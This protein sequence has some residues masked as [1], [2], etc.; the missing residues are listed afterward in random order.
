MPRIRGEICKFKGRLNLP[1]QK[2][3]GVTSCTPH[4]ALE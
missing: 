4:I 2:V 3:Y 1:M